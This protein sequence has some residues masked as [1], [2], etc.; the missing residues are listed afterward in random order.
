[1]DALQGAI[2]GLQDDLREIG[3]YSGRD[4][5][6]IFEEIKAWI[7]GRV[8]SNCD[9]GMIAQTSVH[10]MWLLQAFPPRQG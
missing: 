2:Q 8:S 5:N 9:E 1:M 4:G 10:I 6:E 7:A 3:D